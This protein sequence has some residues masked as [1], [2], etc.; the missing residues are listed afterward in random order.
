MIKLIR[1]A[2]VYAPAHLG[3]KDVLVIADKVVRIADKIEGY[4]G[5]PEVEVFDFSGK[6]LLPVLPSWSS[7]T[8]SSS[9]TANAIWLL[10]GLQRQTGQ[11]P[12]RI[13]R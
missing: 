4:E 3:K 12:F 2:D 13:C 6:K 1:N 8:V 11:I 9:C 10:W 5:M 7:Q